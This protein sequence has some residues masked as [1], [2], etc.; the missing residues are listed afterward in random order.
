MNREHAIATLVRA[1]HRI[2]RTREVLI[3]VMLQLD[4]ARPFSA[5]DVHRAAGPARPVDLVTIYRNLDAFANA[6]LICRADIFEET[7]RFTLAHADHG[8]HHHHV[9]CRQCH[10][11]TAV[12]ACAMAKTT[13][14][15]K[16]LG[17]SEIEYRLEFTGTCKTCRRGARA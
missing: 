12:T 15:V 16:D 14:A 6:G 7:Q 13:G 17:F 11:V 4:H 10:R 3:D 8:H 9:T 5:A 1:K 2:T